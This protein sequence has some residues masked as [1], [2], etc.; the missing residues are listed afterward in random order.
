M[1]CL[2][3][4]PGAARQPRSGGRQD[5][6]PLTLWETWAGGYAPN[7]T[8]HARPHG[9]PTLVHPTPATRLVRADQGTKRPTR[10]LPTGLPGLVARGDLVSR[11]AP[12]K[13]QAAAE[14]AFS[15]SLIRR[16]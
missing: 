16:W 2:I 4:A 14:R 10:L 13:T 1:A 15:A 5:A 9:A 11:P 3:P 7:H 8:P 6:R 12:T